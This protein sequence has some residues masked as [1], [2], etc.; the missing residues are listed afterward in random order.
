M[1]YYLWLKGSGFDLGLH[2]ILIELSRYWSDM[3]R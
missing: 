3:L 1:Y 2:A